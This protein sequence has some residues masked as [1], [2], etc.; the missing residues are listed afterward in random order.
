[1]KGRLGAGLTPKGEYIPLAN[2]IKDYLAEPIKPT[3]NDIEWLSFKNI[4][5]QQMAIIDN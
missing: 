1:L 3:L 4:I 2:K 5:S